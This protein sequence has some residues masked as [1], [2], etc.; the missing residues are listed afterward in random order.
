MGQ[1]L[2]PQAALGLTTYFKSRPVWGSPSLGIS[3]QSYLTWKLRAYKKDMLLMRKLTK[4]QFEEIEKYIKMIS[5]T[6]L[7]DNFGDN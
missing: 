3:N 4:I 1:L 5:T 7:L 2:G 6:V